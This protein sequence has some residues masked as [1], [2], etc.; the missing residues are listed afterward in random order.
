MRRVPAD[1]AGERL[2]RIVA[3]LGEMS[4]AQARRM[5]ESGRVTVDSETTTAPAHRM[6]A[7]MMLRF[8]RPEA[9]PAPAAEDIE[10]L[11]VWEDDHLAVIDKPAGIVTHPG[12]GNPTGTFPVT[13][14][15]H[16][17]KIVVSGDVTQVDLPRHT[18]SGL[19]DGLERLRGIKGFAAV[20]LTAADIVRHRLVQDIV[21]AYKERPGKRR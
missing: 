18:R 7:G 11:V 19:I 10:F 6:E 2:D 16:G 1:L 14:M 9:P 15:G 12:A 8:A 21:D 17:S 4:R 3:I 13:R 20:E 5:I